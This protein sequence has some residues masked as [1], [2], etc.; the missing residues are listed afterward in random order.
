MFNNFLI[1]D[2][3]FVSV[4]IW[5]VQHSWNEEGHSIK[6][7]LVQPASSKANKSIRS[8]EFTDSVRKTEV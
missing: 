4:R 8:Q 3:V 7:V 2:T 5:V 1:A 6:T